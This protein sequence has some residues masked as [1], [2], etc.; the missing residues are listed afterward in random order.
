MSFAGA[1]AVSRTGAGQY[2]GEIHGGWDIRGV[3]NGGYLMAIAGRAM[4]AETDGRRLVSITGHFMN[5]GQ[6]GPVEIDVQQLKSGRSFTTLRS[7]MTAAGKPLL[8]ATGSF[9]ATQGKGNEASLLRGTPP[10]L[11]PPEDCIKATPSESGEFPPPLVSK[12][13][14]RMHPEDAGGALG[15]PTGSAMFRGWFGLPGEEPVEDL[16][17]VL[18][19]DSFPPAIFNAGLP[20]TWTPTLDLTVHV[21]DPGPHEWLMCSLQTRFVT[22]GFLEE[23][24]EIWDQ[25]GNLVALSRQLAVLGR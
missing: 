10:D 23:D 14:L 15:K 7:V 13:D 9:S 2:V 16:A 6:P 25:D 4:A 5:P 12:I 3:S 17:I 22:G 11:P 8:S 1:T 24:G 21:R 20:M 19:S 18:A